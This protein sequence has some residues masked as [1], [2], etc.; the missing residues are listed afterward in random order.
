MLENE[1]KKVEMKSWGSNSFDVA[2]HSLS[3][4]LIHAHDVE[5]LGKSVKGL[6]LRNTT[7]LNVAGGRGKEAEFLIRKGCSTLVLGDIAIEQLLGA[8]RRKEKRRL[9]NMELIV[10]DAEHLP[11]R[12]KTFDLG[13]VYMGL[14]HAPYPYRA[15]SELCEVSGGNVIFVDTMNPLITKIL[16][17]FGLFKKEGCGI[18]P[19]RLE[20]KKVKSTFDRRQTQ[21]G[22]SYFFVPPLYGR[23]DALCAA[24]E[25]LG[26]IINLIMRL[27]RQRTGRLFGNVAII[28]A[29]TSDGMN[30]EEDDKYES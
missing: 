6:D 25:L 7:V 4:R 16:G 19:N 2:P 3:E 22:I 20:E 15:I 14:H 17:S 10:L 26:S 5:L 18:E 30:F 9:G 23:R 8:K 28:R 24:F 11:F 13:Y 1:R 12:L 27:T 29:K 21:V